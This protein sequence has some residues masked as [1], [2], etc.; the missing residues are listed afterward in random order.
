MV[1]VGTAVMTLVGKRIGE[2]RPKL[3][4]RTV[5]LAARS[6]ATYMLVLGGLFVLFPETILLPFTGSHAADEMLVIRDEVVVL[7]RFVAVYTFFDGM[8]IVFAFAIRGAGDTRFPFLY[9]LVTA[10]LVMVVPTYLLVSTGHGGLFRCWSFCAAY[11][12]LL[13][14][15]CL[16]RFLQGKWKSMNVIGTVASIS[17]SDSD[18]S[19]CVAELSALPE[20]PVRMD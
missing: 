16:L 5:W 18:G 19:E 7:L 20:T 4:E 13:G 8:A 6:V 9:T 14:I 17:D 10:W 12:C 2:G 1:G 11:V 3:A 15:G